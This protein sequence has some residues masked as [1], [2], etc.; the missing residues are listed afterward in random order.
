MSI[1]WSD[2]ITCHGSPSPWEQAPAAI[3]KKCRYCG[4]V[5]P[6]DVVRFEGNGIESADWKYGW[7]HKFYLGAPTDGQSVGAAISFGK[8]YSEHLTDVGLSDDAF[9]EVA[10][11]LWRKSG[12]L[13]VREGSRLT[14]YNSKIKYDAIAAEYPATFLQPQRDGAK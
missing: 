6:E 10:R 2:V 9:V 8:F 1:V 5:S 3:A 12:V 11:V 7:P 14:W 4:S 13:F